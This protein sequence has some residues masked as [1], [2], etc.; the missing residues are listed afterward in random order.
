[1]WLFSVLTLC[2]SV[3]DRV[4]RTSTIRWSGLW[5]TLEGACSDTLVLLDAPYAPAAKS[6]RQTGVLE[7]I[8]AAESEEQ[9]QAAGRT[10]FTQLVTQELRA[11]AG[12]PSGHPL[13]ATELHAR[14]VTQYQ[15]ER[16]ARGP[17]V[18]SPLL[19]QVSGNWRV[20]SVTLYPL[21]QTAARPGP[22]LPPPT[23]PGGAGPRLDMTIR[24]AT[25][26]SSSGSSSGG[27]A[28]SLEAWTDWLRMMPDG[29]RD[30]QLQGPVPWLG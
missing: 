22:P 17:R 11:R 8:V 20:P 18:S 3:H 29:I 15:Q 25:S 27:A 9:H 24:L 10:Y 21:R 13:S 30:V 6:Q 23:N 28:L 14:L 4:A 1:M 16:A 26:S 19:L 5:E 12:A 7:V 2:R